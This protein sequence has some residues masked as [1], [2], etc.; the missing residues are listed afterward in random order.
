MREVTV[1]RMR[2]RYAQTVLTVRIIYVI[3]FSLELAHN[4]IFDGAQRLKSVDCVRNVVLRQKL[5]DG[6]KKELCQ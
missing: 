2:E 3:F 1:S 5:Y 6:Q 4:L